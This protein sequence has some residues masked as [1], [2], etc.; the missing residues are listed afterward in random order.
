MLKQLTD[1][2]YI[3]MLKKSADNAAFRHNLLAN[4]IS[5]VNTP[6]YKRRDTADF[7]RMLREATNRESFKA[8]TV[9][10]RHIQFGRKNLDQLYPVAITQD[11][12]RYRNDKSSVDIDLEMA[13]V[14]KNGLRYQAY[15]KELGGYFTS[16]KGILQKA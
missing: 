11:Q 9:N 12:T 1:N 6:G 15:I 2:D 8:Q 13:E 3:S 4:N 16:L 5:N 7:E 10:S 14:S